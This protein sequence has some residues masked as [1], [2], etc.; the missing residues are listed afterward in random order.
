[1][2]L[3]MTAMQERE[4]A[5][6]RN[7]RQNQ[8]SDSNTPPRC[9]MCG[10]AGTHQLGLRFCP[11]TNKLVSERLVT[12]SVQCNKYILP[13]GQDLPRVPYGWIGGVASFIRQQTGTVSNRDPPPHLPNTGVVGTVGLMY[14]DTEILTGNT[15]A[16]EMVSSDY[17]SNPT[18]RS[19]RDTTN[20]FDP[21][22]R[23]DRGKAPERA[24]ENAPAPIRQP[25]LQPQPVQQPPQVQPP[26]Q[27]QVRFAP[28]PT[29][30]PNKVNVPQPP[31]PINNQ[32]GWKNSRPG[33]PRGGA[34]DVEMKDGDSKKQANTGPQYHFS[35]K[36]QDHA[37]PDNM[38]THIGGMKVEVP[39]FQLLGLSPQL[40]RMMSESTRTRREYGPSKDGINK[41]A[42][43]SQFA[44][45]STWDREV[46]E[47]TGLRGP[48]SDESHAYVEEGDPT[49]K[50]FVFWCNNAAVEIPQTR[51]FAMTVGDIRLTLNGVEFLAML[52]S[53]SELNVAGSHLP[54]AASLP[55]DFD[56]MRWKL[57]GINGDYERL[58]GCIIEAP[59]RIGGHDFSHHIFVSQQ[60]IGRHDIIL[61]QPFLQWFSLRMDYDRGSHAKLYLWA[62]GDKSRRPTLMI[63]ITDPNSSRNASAIKGLSNVTSYIEEVESEDFCR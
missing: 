3:M 39:L 35:S 28:E 17:V 31:N 6:N 58:R 48:D 60:S 12:F 45:D 15:F 54:E 7:S 19:G 41:S 55:M 23:P 26:P 29:P 46:T 22:N 38:F 53:G 56:G 25:P 8:G 63:S 21:I 1:M 61:G 44:A 49:L 33:N 16:L 5:R 62:D 11:E 32:Q 57:K 18:T 43:Y 50:E 20:R 13:D 42:E 10:Q 59:I 24:P 47:V 9:F 30:I 37:N 27:Q 40:S 34:Q 51:L 36:I 14:D 4:E 2:T 52:D